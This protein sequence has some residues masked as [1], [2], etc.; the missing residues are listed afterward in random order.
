MPCEY[1]VRL[2]EE[3][4]LGEAS[5]SRACES[6][7]FAS[8]H[9]EREFLPARDARSTRLLA[10]KNLQLLAQ[11]QDLKILVLVTLMT[12]PDEVKKQGDRVRKKQR[13]A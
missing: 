13:R 9:D 3:D 11:K 12:H 8:K 6:S 1:G 4:N 10:L 7:T 2:E 5:T